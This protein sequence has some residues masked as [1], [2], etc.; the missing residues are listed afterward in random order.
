MKSYAIRSTLAA[1][2]AAV[3]FASIAAADT[4]TQT[5]ARKPL[6]THAPMQ[7]AESGARGQRAID[8]L[9]NRLPEVAAWYRKSPEQLRELL[10][11]DSR[12]RIDRQGRLYV[13]EELD[14]QPPQRK[15]VTKAAGEGVVPL[16]QTFTLNSR[17]GAARTIYLD[18]NGAVLVNT[19]WNS[20]GNTLNAQPFDADGNTGSFSDDELERIQ[21]IWQRVAEDYAPFDVNVTTQ[22]PAADA[23]TRSSLSDTTYGT[24]A[25]ITN[26]S[27]VYD[28]GCGGVAYIGIYDDTSDFYKPALVFW[29]ALGPSD[30][31]DVAEA[32]SHE[33]GHN[34]GL[35][36][37]GYSGGGYYPG[38][39]SGAT[40]WAPIMGVGYY[41]S[42][43]QWSKGQYST[44]NNTEDDFVVAQDNGLPLRADDHGDDTASA[45]ALSATPSGSTS[46][47][48]GAGVIERST[49][50]DYFSFTSGAGSATITLTPDE[51][52]ANLDAR[53]T[54]RDAA[55]NVIVRS[56]PPDALAASISFTVPSAG[57][58][59]VTVN[60]VRNGDVLGIGYSGYGSVGQYKITG[61]VPAP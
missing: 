39:G 27:G 1:G 10:L 7:L 61:T 50:R 20:G 21:G 16:D 48:S 5:P 17:P 58:Y 55:D 28:C 60:G 35:N 31:K 59:F 53:I 3:S 49:D 25:L 30:E 13:V 6:S 18:F 45:T 37:D 47:L 51:R 42:L 56:N 15:A 2:L 32:T 38:H 40:G 14:R 33:V 43:V 9:G 44:A 54:I 8:L 29:D 23:L 12:M 11:K 19:A 26:R 36:H 52:S 41:Q 22:E 46:L 4:G 57:T 34:I 24:T